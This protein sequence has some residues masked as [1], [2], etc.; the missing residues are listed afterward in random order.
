MSLG[1]AAVR[2]TPLRRATLPARGKDWSPATRLLT[3]IFKQSGIFN[4]LYDDKTVPIPPL[5]EESG[6]RSATGGV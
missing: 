5:T 6:A 1:R 4:F 2:P 3:A